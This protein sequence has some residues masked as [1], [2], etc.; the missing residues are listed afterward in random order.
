VLDRASENVVP[1][2]IAMREQLFHRIRRLP[3]YVFGEV[4]A[5]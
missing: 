1:M 4:N 5:M 2:R 3:P